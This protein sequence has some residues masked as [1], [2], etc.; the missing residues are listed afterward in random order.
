MDELV[1][2]IKD[3]RQLY[4][5]FKEQA[6]EAHAKKQA[7]EKKMID[8]LK[9]SGRTAYECEGV[10]NVYFY[11]KEVYETPKTVAEKQ[12][13][14]DY[15]EDKYGADALRSLQSIHSSTLNSWANKEV[16][17]GEVMQIP[18][19]GQPTVTEVFNFRKG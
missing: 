9:S 11:T 10:A 17:T 13:L 15:I 6:S 14:F 19:L 7:L 8:Y 5:A 4:E 3:A 18:G 2:E 1:R 12:L 16:E